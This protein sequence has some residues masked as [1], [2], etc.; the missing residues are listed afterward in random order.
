MPSLPASIRPNGPSAN[1]RQRLDEIDG[2][3]P[4]GR[5]RRLRLQR[6]T[7]DFNG[8]NVGAATS[9]SFAGLTGMRSRDNYHFA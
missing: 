9:R 7:V 8:L 4:S 3:P 2:G 1:A 6:S 5:C